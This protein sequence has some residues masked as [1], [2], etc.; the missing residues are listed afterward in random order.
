MFLIKAE[1]TWIHHTWQQI[2]RSLGFEIP[3]RQENYR[4]ITNSGATNKFHTFRAIKTFRDLG[5]N[6]WQAPDSASLDETLN[7]LLK[8]MDYTVLLLLVNGH[9][10]EQGAWVNRLKVLFGRLDPAL[11]PKNPLADP[12]VAGPLTEEQFYQQLYFPAVMGNPLDHANFFNV[13]PDRRN[14]LANPTNSAVASGPNVED[15]HY[16]KQPFYQ[17]LDRLAA[18]EDPL[19]YAVEDEPMEM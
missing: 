1:H 5:E 11:R 13:W 9:Q 18:T 7:L 10:D 4:L 15:F 2:H 17:P 8:E 12:T 16:R 19:E 14:Q 6:R 3:S